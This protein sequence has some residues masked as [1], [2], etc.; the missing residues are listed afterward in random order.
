MSTSGKNTFKKVL[1][2]GAGIYVAGMIAVLGIG[3]IVSEFTGSTNEDPT[4]TE[5][6]GNRDIADFS[7][8]LAPDY[9]PK[10]GPDTA[11]VKIV[12]FSDFQCPFCK[13]S[14]PVLRQILAAYPEDVQLIYRHFPLDYIHAN[15]S[16]LA[17]ASMCANEQDKFW[18][19]HDKLFQL[20]DTLR[21]EDL[22]TI[23][24]SVGIDTRK[25]RQCQ[26]SR[27]Y[28]SIIQQDLSDGLSLG[29]RGTPTWF[30]NGERVEGV[31]PYAIWEQIIQELL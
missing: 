19:F 24:Q 12:E 1:G 29:S 13:A 23:A 6:Q 5:Y 14:A 28:E 4:I 16:D 7:G 21:L 26:D 25:F 17:H 3:Y 9:A 10:E 15:A 22:D 20:Q 31:L 27:K 8:D 18:P 2:Y 30:V 11:K